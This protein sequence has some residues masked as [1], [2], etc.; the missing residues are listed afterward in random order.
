MQAIENFRESLLIHFSCFAWWNVNILEEV[1]KLET[2]QEKML[3][4][5]QA[6][7]NMS[8]YLLLNIS[9]ANPRYVVN[10]AYIYYIFLYTLWEETVFWK[11]WIKW[12]GLGGSCWFYSNILPNNSDFSFVRISWNIFNIYM[13]INSVLDWQM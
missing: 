8:V 5:L 3:H 4:R 12:M 2:I 9:V 13:Y 11:G 1:G 10:L 6:L 7:Y